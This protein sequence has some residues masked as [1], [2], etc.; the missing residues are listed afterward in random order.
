MIFAS[1]MPNE[2]ALVNYNASYFASAHGGAPTSRVGQAFFSAVSR[3]RLVFLRRFLDEHQVKVDKILEFGPGPGFFAR[4]WLEAQPR[5]TYLA[6]ETDRSCHEVLT[7]IGVQLV[8]GPSA[9]P[10]DLVVMSHV[11]EHVT[12]PVDFVRTATQMLRPGGALFIE[13][14][15]NDWAHKE[16]DEPHVLFFDKP[17]MYKLLTDLG[18]VDV[19]MNY[20]GRKISELQSTSSVRNKLMALRYR[21]INWGLIAPFARVRPGMESLADPLERAMV[22]P[23]KAHEESFEPAWWLRAVARKA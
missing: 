20:Y 11:L 6:V 23:Y 21:L 9:M 17:S 10:V 19:E 22:T 7:R 15:C 12:A 8:D 2:A 3:L 18:F 13:V 4:S 5:C 16:L 14:P 1:P